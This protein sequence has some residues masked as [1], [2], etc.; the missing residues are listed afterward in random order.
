MVF[1][2]GTGLN[3]L[4]LVD[5]FR[6]VVIRNTLLDECYSVRFGIGV[7]SSGIAVVSEDVFGTDRDLLST[8]VW[9]VDPV[10]YPDVAGSRVVHPS[11]RMGRLGRLAGLRGLAGSRTRIARV[12]RA[13]VGR[14]GTSVAVGLG[15]VVILGRRGR[16]CRLVVDIDVLVGVSRLLLGC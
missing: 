10:A 6:T 9:H 12:R 15:V 8:V 1:L 11:V 7:A 14:L 5:G 2:V 4:G 13:V 3:R 16:L